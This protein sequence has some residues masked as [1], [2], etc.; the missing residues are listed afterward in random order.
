MTRFWDFS[1]T[2]FSLKLLTLSVI[3]KWKPS[4]IST[5]WALEELLPWPQLVLTELDILG[6]GFSCMW[7]FFQFY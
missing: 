1:I 7:L 2:I 6:L 5:T 3:L 4:S